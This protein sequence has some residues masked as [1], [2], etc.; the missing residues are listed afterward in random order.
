MSAAPTLRAPPP[1][2][3]DSAPPS[4]AEGSAW[5]PQRRRGRWDTLRTALFW[6]HLITGVVAGA[7]VLIMSATGVALT[8]QRQMTAWA[9]GTVTPPAGAARLP[10]DT[11]VARVRAS[12]ETVTGVTLRADPRAPLAVG[13]EQRRTVLVDPYTGAILEGSPRLRAFFHEVERWHRSLA[14][15]PSVRAPLGVQLTGASNL[16]FLFLLCTGLVLWWP[17]KLSWRSVRAVLVPNLSARGRARDWNWHHVLGL[18]SAP[19]LLL[20]VGSAAFISYQWPGALTTRMLGGE[21]TRA[22]GAP[23]GGAAVG[24]PEAGRLEGPRAL[25]VSLDTAF[26]RAGA[27]AP[28]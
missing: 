10:L 20:V 23:R 1:A 12:G 4:V 28:G 24:R 25:A 6:A 13:V 14:M 8:Y 11:L 2:P 5:R 7:V 18:W 16:A 15:G 19:V 9:G 17:R 27:A 22:E 26:A 21:P 3:V